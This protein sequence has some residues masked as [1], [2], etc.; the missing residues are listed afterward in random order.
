[1]MPPQTVQK[2]TNPTMQITRAATAKP[3]A[4]CVT[5]YTTCAGGPGIGGGGGI[6]ADSDEPDDVLSSSTMASNPARFENPPLR[7]AAEQVQALDRQPP[8]PTGTFR[9][10]KPLGPSG[11]RRLLFLAEWP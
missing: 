5:W 3:L 1:M 6:E 8:T 4:G 11:F 2:R 7:A 9:L 10:E